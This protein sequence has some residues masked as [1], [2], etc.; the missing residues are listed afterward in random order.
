[1]LAMDAK[2]LR[3]YWEPDAVV[4]LELTSCQL[5]SAKA[6]AVQ[7]EAMEEEEESILHVSPFMMG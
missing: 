6:T 7:S 5:A 2:C 4:V 3:K 1:M